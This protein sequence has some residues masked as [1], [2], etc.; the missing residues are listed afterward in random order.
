MTDFGADDT[1][2]ASERLAAMQRRYRESVAEYRSTM[3]DIESQVIKGLAQMATVKVEVAS[4]EDK[5]IAA[6]RIGTGLAAPGRYEL[7]AAV[8]RAI[9]DAIVRVPR[10]KAP[11]HTETM[12]DAFRA[13]RSL[14]EIAQDF[15]LAERLDEVRSYAGSDVSVSMRLGC[16]DAIHFDESWYRS[17][18]LGDI[19]TAVVTRVNAAFDWEDSNG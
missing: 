1:A 6:I 9:Q 17:A 10:M 12:V 8:T 2:T 16:L 15:R 13:G 4:A 5:R 3:A 14:A 18:A 11:D 7:A 19:E